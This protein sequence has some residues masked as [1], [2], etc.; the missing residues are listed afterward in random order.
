MVSF[1]EKSIEISVL[2]TIP[3]TKCLQDLIRSAPQNKKLTIISYDSYTFYFL[4]INGIK[5]RVSNTENCYGSDTSVIS[6]CS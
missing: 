4:V 5:D 1:S 6:N 3:E 2:S